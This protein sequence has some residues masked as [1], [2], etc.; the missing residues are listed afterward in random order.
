MLTFDSSSLQTNEFCNTVK[1]STIIYL[2]HLAGASNCIFLHLHNSSLDGRASRD[3]EIEGES[4]VSVL[5][6]PN[7]LGLFDGVK[8]LITGDNILREEGVEYFLGEIT[9]ICQSSSE[10]SES[11]TASK[12]GMSESK[13]PSSSSLWVSGTCLVRGARAAA[14]RDGAGARFI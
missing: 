7:K 8:G 2:E 14:T 13:S 6:E 12:A 1:S 5:H 10:A 9:L 4:M 3:A 11:D